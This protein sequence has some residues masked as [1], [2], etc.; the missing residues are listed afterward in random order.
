[1]ELPG[2]LHSAPA[3]ALLL[4]VVVVL[5]RVAADNSILR[6]SF[7]RCS[8][9]LEFGEVLVSAGVWLSG[10]MLGKGSVLSNPGKQEAKGQQSG[11]SL[12]LM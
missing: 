10:S 6:R 7:S 11:K 2:K 12:A 5:L 4:G 1:M 3:L 8:W 9:R